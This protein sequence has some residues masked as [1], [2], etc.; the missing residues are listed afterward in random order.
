M[1]K[2]P[3]VISHRGVLSIPRKIV[4]RHTVLHVPASFEIVLLIQKH[5]PFYIFK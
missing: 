1:Y 5:G 3:T 4:S 2:I